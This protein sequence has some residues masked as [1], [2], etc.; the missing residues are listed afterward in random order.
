M[1]VA[2]RSEESSGDRPWLRR[3][4]DSGSSIL[5]ISWCAHRTRYPF[6]A[7]IR[8]E[9]ALRISSTAPGWWSAA[10]GSFVS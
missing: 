6:S 7:R 5:G 3:L 8:C 2:G 1:T 9:S 10:Y 4:F